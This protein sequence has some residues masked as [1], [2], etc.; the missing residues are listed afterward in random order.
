MLDITYDRRERL[1]K[2]AHPESG[3]VL[4]APAGKQN[5]AGLFKNAVALLDPDLYAA[6]LRWLEDEPA[7][8]RVIWRGVELVANSRVETFP[9]AGDG[10]VAAKVDSRDEY[11]RYSLTYMNGRLVCECPHWQDLAAPYSRTGRR[12]CKH[13]AAFTLYQRVREDR[14]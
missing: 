11:G 14:F 12:V 4:T 3:E 6:A 10:E 1:Y 9:G 7:L 2:W 13:L 5:K 8:E